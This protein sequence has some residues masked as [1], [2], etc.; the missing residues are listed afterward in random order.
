MKWNQVEEIYKEKNHKSHTLTAAGSVVL[1][2]VVGIAT[3]G[4]GFAAGLAAGVANTLGGG[5]LAEAAGQVAA[6][7]FKYLVQQTAAALVN[8]DFKIKATMKDVTSKRNLRGLANAMG[9]AAFVGAPAGHSGDLDLNG[10]AL[11]FHNK[12]VKKPLKWS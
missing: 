3:A 1:A 8:N 9:V 12:I 4:T 7:G 2:L 11:N 5:L 10:V 6:A